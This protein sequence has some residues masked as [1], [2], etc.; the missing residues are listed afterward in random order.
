MG[1]GLFCFFA[2]QASAQVQAPLKP[3]LLLLKSYDSTQA[4]S[5]WVMSEK[6]DGVRAY[7]NGQQLI[8]RNGKV[9][10]APSWFLSAFPA[11]ELDGELWLKRQA[12]ADTVSIVN[13]QTAHK[14]WQA[15]T[16]QVFEIPNQAGGLLN[17]L[18]VLERYLNQ[19]PTEFIQIIE[20]TP[21]KNH[22]Q[23]TR[24]LKRVLALGAEGLVVR[25]PAALYHA[26]RSSLAFKYKLK[27]D[28]E[29]TVSGYTPGKGKYTNQVGA[30]V[31]E[32]KADQ[33]AHLT[34]PVQRQIK[35]GSGLN[36]ADRKTPPKIG[37]TITFQYMGLT[38]NGLPRF[39]VFLR[40]RPQG[41]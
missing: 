8:S 36:D 41:G 33:F 1:L 19:H 24:E 15:I 11:F 39:P 13:T 16:Y 38:K 28:A 23:A 20:Q 27:Q 35:V 12:F 29:C 40:V 10:A 21:V 6:L 14:G 5:G 26:G 9:F 17:R 22:L 32:L 34:T 7:W 37:S 2:T 31:C 4:I 3:S 30:L 18:S 25:D